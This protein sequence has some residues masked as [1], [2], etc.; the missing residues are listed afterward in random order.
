MISGGCAE[1]D[2]PNTERTRFVRVRR[3]SISDGHFVAVSV[4]KPTPG[5]TVLATAT[6]DP[7]CLQPRPYIYIVQKRCAAARVGLQI[8]RRRESRSTFAARSCYTLLQTKD[9]TSVRASAAAEERS[10]CGWRCQADGCCASPALS[11]ILAVCSDHVRKVNAASVGA[12]F[13]TDS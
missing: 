13:G 8:K 2:P 11:S 6:R 7:S 12:Q 4:A 5:P 1:V 3:D 9:S 10:N